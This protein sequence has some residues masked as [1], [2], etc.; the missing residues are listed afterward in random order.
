[1]KM[2]TFGNLLQLTYYKELNRSV[3]ILRR[4]IVVRVYEVKD[5]L[6]IS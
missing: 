4:R 3:Y 2:I 6:S 5:C 1:M